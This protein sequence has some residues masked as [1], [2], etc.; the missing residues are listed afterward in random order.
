MINA[1]RDDETS[2]NGTS[3]FHINFFTGDQEEC[4]INN[5]P[6]NISLDTTGIITYIAGNGE[7]YTLFDIDCCEYFGYEN[8]LNIGDGTS[9]CYW[10]PPLSEFVEVILGPDNIELIIIKPNGEV[11][12]PTEQCCSKRGGTWTIPVTSDG[13]AGKPYCKKTPTVLDPTGNTPTG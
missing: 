9:P 13:E 5:C 4:L 8:Y 1:G 7:I 12:K 11:K 6:D 10:C 3:S 2:N